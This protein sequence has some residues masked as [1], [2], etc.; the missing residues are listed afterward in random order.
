VKAWLLTWEWGNDAAAVADRVIL[1]L[2]PRWSEERVAALVE[3]IY[4][5]C[6]SSLQ[7]IAHYAKRPSNNP[8]RAKRSDNSIIC[9]HNPWLE[10]RK[11]SE[12]TVRVEP[13]DGMEVVSWKEPD[14]YG[15]VDG[16]VR[17]LADGS[18]EIFR[19]RVSGPPN[20]EAIWDRLKGAF[21]A[22]WEPA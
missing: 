3:T 8:Y 16:H 19:R 20:H 4:A 18:K 5:M 10:A 11:V 2:N 14:R 22:G 21:K 1:F 15:L 9:G 6:H 17:K 13:A 7:E 12:L